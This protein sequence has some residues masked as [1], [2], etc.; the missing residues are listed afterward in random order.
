MV[1]NQIQIILKHMGVDYFNI[2]S[3]VTRTTSIRVLFSLSSIYKLY[4]YQMNVK[5]TFLNR[6]LKE[7]VYMEQTESYTSK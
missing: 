6:D 4:V 5:M 3:P 7:K 2:Y 1:E